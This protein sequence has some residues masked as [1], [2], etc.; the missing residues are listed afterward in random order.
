MG[1]TYRVAIHHD[2][3]CGYIEYNPATKEVKVVLGDAAKRREVEAFLNNRHA[4][5]EAQKGLRDFRDLSAV[6]TESLAVLKLALTR[7][8]QKTGVLVDWSR[9]VSV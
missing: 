6:P 1:E 5:R 9:P 8:W 3:D 2:S 7:L 4:L